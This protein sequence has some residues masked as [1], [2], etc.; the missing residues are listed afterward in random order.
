MEK[1]EKYL[2]VIWLCLGAL[3]FVYTRTGRYI[4]IAIVLGP[5]F[6]LRFI[7]S[8]KPVKGILLTWLG[9]IVA[10]M[11]ESGIPSGDGLSIAFFIIGC[12]FKAFVLGL[13]FFADRI[14]FKNVKGFLSTLVF[15]IS[16]TALYFVISKWS[17]LYEGVAIFFSYTQFGNMPLIQALSIAGV[18]GMVFIL[19][20]FASTIIW[21]WENNFNWAEI[22]KGTLT[23]ILVGVFFL[24]YGGIKTSPMLYDYDGETVKIATVT[25]PFEKGESSPNLLKIYENREFS[26]LKKEMNFV[27]EKVEIAAKSNAKIVAFQEC[28]LIIPEEQKKEL[29]NNLKHIAIENNVY[30]C[31]NYIY[32][33]KLKEG[34]RYN[35][36][37]G[38]MELSDEEEGRNISLLIN[39][40]GDVLVDYMKHN[41]VLGEDN[42]VL[43]GPGGLNVVETPYGRIGIATCRDM[44]FPEYMRSVATQNAD[45][46]IAPSY[47]AFKA[48]SI[49]YNQMLRSVEY[50]F[51]FVRPCGNGLSIAVDYNGNILAQQNFFTT[52]D[53]IMFA[54]VPR[55]GI[56][57]LYAITGDLFSWLCLIGMLVFIVMG[58]VNK[59][60]KAT[61]N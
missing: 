43:H 30:L 38:M 56:K 25:I 10:M 41:L 14:L 35:N 52:T 12:S 42:Y 36:M 44:E 51:S 5:I 55:K 18:W 4:P 23:Y 22:K 37:F 53:G 19:S 13:P 50:G 40:N 45:I 61:T 11:I 21:M 20:W 39:N 17:G 6:I 34:K 57:T 8:K 46:V 1:K 27:R 3:L 2:N 33:P 32:F 54:D 7:R 28:A 31:Y 59:R 16:A 58:I 60:K 29:L 24:I 49:S 15:P 48:L 9:L 47:E 26:D